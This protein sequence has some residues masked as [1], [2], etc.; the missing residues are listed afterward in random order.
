MTNI[1]R[2][3]ATKI[4]LT[5][6]IL[7][8]FGFMFSPFFTAI[9]LAG[10]FGFALEPVVSRYAPRK[11]RRKLSTAILIFGF[12]LIVSLPVCFVVYRIIVKA[13][14]V[15]RIGVQNT[16][17]YNSLNN[18]LN[19][20]LSNGIALA[21]KIGIDPETV[22]DVSS[23]LSEAG[24]FL[25]TY[26]TA[27]VGYL[28]AFILGLFI[29]TAAL[30]FFLTE[31]KNIKKSISHLDLLTPGELDKIIHVVQRSSYVSFISTVIIGALQ[32]VTVAIAAAICGY[33][34]FFIVFV[35]TFIFGLIPVIG[36][37]PVAI[38]LSLLSFVQG[39]FGEGIGLA[40][41]AVVAGTV[42]NVVKPLIVNAADE[43]LHPVVSLIALIGGVLVY[44]IPGLL[45]GPVLTQLAFKIIPILFNKNGQMVEDKS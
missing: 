44:G 20:V 17:I 3:K 2:H 13:Q 4:A 16:P 33:T 42:D 37:A 40:I 12:F 7:L 34:E 19:S 25:V 26:T 32:A 5:S 45:L 29:F 39:H 35:I 36:A 28:P 31:S 1:E 43:E 6:L 23:L 10:L 8:S 38:A 22:P 14:E 30:Y 27:F 21:K 41:A 11:K 9:L 24:R 15:S 18:A